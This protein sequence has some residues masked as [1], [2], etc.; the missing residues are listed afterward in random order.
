MGRQFLL[1]LT[2]LGLETFEHVQEEEHGHKY[3]LPILLH[4][5]VPRYCAHDLWKLLLEGIRE[6]ADEADQL[7]AHWLSRKIL[8]QGLDRPARRF[9]TFGGDFALDLV[10]RMIDLADLFSDSERVKMGA[11]LVAEKVGLPTYLVETL[12]EFG[13]GAVVTHTE[14]PLPRPRITIDPFSGAGPSVLLPAIPDAAKS[15]HWILQGRGCR[16]AFKASREDREVPLHQSPQWRVAIEARGTSKSFDFSEAKRA[17]VYFFDPPTG[18]LLRDQDRP[19]SDGVLALA[20]RATQFTADVLTAT[21]VPVRQELPRLSGTWTNWTLRELELRSLAHFTVEFSDVANTVLRETFSVA[22]RGRRPSLALPPIEGIRDAHGRNVFARVPSL[23]VDPGQTS[24]D[25][26][27]VR[28]QGSG[29][30]VQ[31]TLATLSCRRETF[32][33]SGVLPTDRI[34]AGDLQV[35]GPLGSDLRTSFAVVPGLSFHQPPRVIGPDESVTVDVL[36]PRARLNGQDDRVSV[37]FGAGEHTKAIEV[38]ATETAESIELHVTVPRLL[39]VVRRT[40]QS[41]SPFTHK[42]TEVGLDELEQ[43][44]AD[45]LLVRL[46]RPDEVKLRLVGNGETQQW[47]EVATA[48]GN[49]GRWTFPLLPFATSAAQSG[50]ARLELRI[51]AGA[52]E[53]LAAVI[54]ATYETWGISFESIVDEGEGLSCCEVRWSERRPFPGREIR[55]WSRHRPWEEPVT[56]PVDD[57]ARGAASFSVGADLTGGPYLLEIGL[58]DAWL[59]PHRPRAEA[60]NVTPVQVGDRANLLAHQKA[61]D[62]S[63]PIQ[64]LELLIAANGEGS[65][66]L[67]N[68]AEGAME[69][70]FAALPALLHEL[71]RSA[72]KNR[73]FVRLCDLAV[74][75]PAA[76]ATWIVAGALDQRELVQLVIALLPGLLEAAP[77]GLETGQHDRVWEAS[78]VAGAALD[79]CRRGNIAA[80]NR[81]EYFTGWDPSLPAGE[82]DEQRG[83][84][85]LPDRGGP[86]DPTLAGLPQP[87]LAAIA[88]ELRPDEVKPLL[89]SGYLEAGLAFL[90]ET[91]PDREVAKRWRSAYARLNDER[92]RQDD[93]CSLYLESL[94]PIDGTPAWC[95]LPQELLAAAFHLVGCSAE[96]V[97]ATTALWDATDFAHGLV[98]RSILVAVA[99]KHLGG[100]AHG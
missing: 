76:L 53:A 48:A 16:Q 67:A 69:Q 56:V 34:L 80:A 77:G 100:H 84:A 59:A 8:L 22:S 45:A 37:E 88:A 49:D 58:H 68:A 93:L 12:F 42:P 72:I 83:V 74:A 90:E 46:G 50:L 3:V 82:D 24:L 95:R 98:E 97:P 70:V 23:A 51:A 79:P 61:M 91:S 27:R 25:A 29:F 18:E 75:H 64:A 20:P 15:D 54:R 60:P 85:R 9:L 6:G 71:G 89:R 35:L 78:V 26:W 96:R 14:K 41:P 39:W 17:P 55:L 36:V 7:V 32:E 2:S 52:T 13:D 21:P 19:R 87:R 63:T 94:V 47:T 62:R 30:D 99:L 40:T 81:W 66:D 1:S 5:G 10:Q 33:L 73:V 44:D 86:I 43:G 11:R 38:V 92:V 28:F 4:G 57:D 31:T 65:G